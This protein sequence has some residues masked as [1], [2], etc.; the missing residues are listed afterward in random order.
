MDLKFTTCSMFLIQTGICAIFAPFLCPLRK[1]LFKSLSYISFYPSHPSATVF[2]QPNIFRLFRFSPLLAKY[3]PSPNTFPLFL[4]Q[5]LSRIWIKDQFADLSGPF[6]LVHHENIEVSQLWPFSPAAVVGRRDL[7]WEEEGP[8]SGDH[9][10][11]SLRQTRTITFVFLFLFIFV[12]IFLQ[13]YGILSQTD[14]DYHICTYL[15]WHLN[16]E[17]IMTF[18]RGKNTKGICQML[19]VYSHQIHDQDSQL[20]MRTNGREVQSVNNW[21]A[22]VRWDIK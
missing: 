3:F 5:S 4:L 12:F 21:D 19:L 2:P 15:H 9:M 11:S 16:W 6:G 7:P 8:A 20:G 13:S 14:T 22:V 1:D 17:W 18:I 10:S